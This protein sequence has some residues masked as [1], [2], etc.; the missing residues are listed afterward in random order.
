MSNW[1]KDA[2]DQA[3]REMGVKRFKTWGEILSD[4]TFALKHFFRILGGK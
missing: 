1:I 2:W 3:K 4:A